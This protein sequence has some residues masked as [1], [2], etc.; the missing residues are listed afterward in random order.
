MT[1]DLTYSTVRSVGLVVERMVLS[2]EKEDGREEISANARSLSSSERPR[3]EMVF[4]ARI[5]ALIWGSR[6]SDSERVLQKTSS[7]R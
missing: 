6:G 1:C 7:I 3:L 5:R 4:V 2:V